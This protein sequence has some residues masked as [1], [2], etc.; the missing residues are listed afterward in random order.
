[1][2]LKSMHGFRADPKF[3]MKL[4][5]DDFWNGEYLERGALALIPESIA[6]LIRSGNRGVVARSIPESIR[7]LFRTKGPSYAQKKYARYTNS[8]RTL[9]VPAQVDQD[10]HAL[11]GG[12]RRF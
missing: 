6:D 7:D 12:R 1:M 5:D 10:G 4:S 11:L 8:E 3:A 2:L 9:R